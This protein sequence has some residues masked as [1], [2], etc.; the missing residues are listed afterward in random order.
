VIRPFQVEADAVLR[1]SAPAAE[2]G[3][4]TAIHVDAAEGTLGIFR[5]D[6]T[7]LPATATLRGGRIRLIYAVGSDECGGARASCDT[8]DLQGPIEVY[9]AGPDWVESDVTYSSRPDQG[10]LLGEG[11]HIDDQSTTVELGAAVGEIGS[12]RNVNDQITLLV[13][14]GDGTS[15]VISARENPVACNGGEPFPAVELQLE[16]CSNEP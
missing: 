11:L 7:G 15:F 12:W 4:A 6:T 14:A 5:F 16:Y 1:P 3:D 13:A 9:F 8:I 10:P 2:G